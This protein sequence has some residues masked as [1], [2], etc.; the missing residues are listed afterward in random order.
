M[1]QHPSTLVASAYSL[2]TRRGYLSDLRIWRD[3]CSRRGVSAIP[4]DPED[5]ASFLREQAEHKRPATI[6]RYAASISRAHSLL[7]LPSPTH[8]DTVRLSIKA[9]HREKGRRQKQA[10]PLTRAEIDA[11]LG[12]LSVRPT[13]LQIRD[14]ALLAVAYDTMARRSELAALLW[15]DITENPDSHSGTVL[16]RRS[17]NDPEGEGSTRYLAPDTM[18]LL[19]RWRDLCRTPTVFGLSGKAI[20]AA[21][22]RAAR[23]AGL[24]GEYSAHSTRVGCAQDMAAAGLGTAEI[25]QAG[26]WHSAEMVARYTERQT[27]QRGAS[28]KLAELQG[29]HTK[30]K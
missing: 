7:S 3:W 2:A 19:T 28:A 13:P 26:G 16:I 29:R 30:L 23:S 21:I 10:P 15:E 18:I 24:E 11:I 12:A 5:V 27:A 25:M 9:I 1:T 6:R 22:R 4:A 20:S 17:K 14:A 8:S